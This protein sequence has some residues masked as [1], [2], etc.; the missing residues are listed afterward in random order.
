[1]P[2]APWKSS[3]SA[4]R[5][6]DESCRNPDNPSPPAKCRHACSRG[7]DLIRVT[8]IPDSR[9][10]IKEAV[11]DSRRRVGPGGVVFTSGGIGPTHDDVTCVAAGCGAWGRGGV[12]GACWQGGGLRH[13]A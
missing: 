5:L 12:G 11:L 9:E 1:M 2:G 10:T 8:Y 4:P 6:R 13:G 3:D 7:V